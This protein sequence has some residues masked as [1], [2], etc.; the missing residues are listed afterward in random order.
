MFEFRDRMGRKLTSEKVVEKAI[1]RMQNIWLDFMLMILRWIGHIP[2]HTIRCACYRL[3][4]VT[5][6]KGTV[7]HMWCSFFEPGNVTIGRDTI[8]G[9]HAFLDGRDKIVIG[10]HVGIASSVM[11]YN[12]AHD[13]DSED[14]HAVTKPTVIKDYAFIGPRA[15]LLPGVTVGKGAV[16]AAGAVVTKNVADYAVVGGVPAQF[17]RE[18]KNK[19]PRYRL[20][21]ARLFQ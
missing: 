8:V 13:I 3:A 2:S 21:R 7:I 4:G 19:N 15:I 20:G 16:V 17:I 18:R 14:F 1:I 10:N 5:I 6:G 12:S 11:I 9:D